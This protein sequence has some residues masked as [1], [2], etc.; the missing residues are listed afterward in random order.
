MHKDVAGNEIMRGTY[1]AYCAL[2]GRSACFKYGVVTKLVEKLDPPRYNSQPGDPP[3]YSRSVQLIS[4]DKG[5]D[6]KWNLQGKNDKGRAKVIT[7][8][9]T[10]RI[11]VVPPELVPEDARKVLDE[12]MKERGM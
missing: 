1:I 3:T 6:E 11:L 9:Y 10:D 4:V 7:L 5:W 8:G 2:H 12:E